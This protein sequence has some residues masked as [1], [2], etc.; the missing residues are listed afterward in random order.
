MQQFSLRNV[1]RLADVEPFPAIVERELSYGELEE[2]AM[3]TAEGQRTDSAALR[4][5]GR[6]DLADRLQRGEG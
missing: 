3:M 1:P 2:L 5:M 4:A 6:A